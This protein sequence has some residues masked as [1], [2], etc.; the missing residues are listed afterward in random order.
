MGWLVRGTCYAD[1]QTARDVFCTGIEGVT[2]TGRMVCSGTQM[3]TGSHVIDFQ[4]IT[5]KPDGAYTVINWNAGLPECDPN[6]FAQAQSGFPF[7]LSASDGFLLSVAIVGVWAAAFAV[8]AAIRAL[9][10]D[11]DGENLGS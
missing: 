6:L 5:Q 1:Q 10:G 4:I 2:S 3:A 11:H 9:G 8:R 7:N